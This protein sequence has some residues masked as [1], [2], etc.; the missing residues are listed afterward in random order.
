VCPSTALSFFSDAPA[1]VRIEIERDGAATMA[2]HF[3]GDPRP[4][5][6]ISAL[7]PF[8]FGLGFHLML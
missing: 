7:F 5:G 1:E 6:E 3:A 4:T 2:V 8:L